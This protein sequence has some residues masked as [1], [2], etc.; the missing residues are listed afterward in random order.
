MPIRSWPQQPVIFFLAVVLACCVG[1]IA[2]AGEAVASAA[3]QVDLPY[4]AERSEPI[5]H[6]VDFSV[7]V[8]PP[9]HCKVL[10]VWLPLP[11]SDAAQ[12]ISNRKIATFPEEVEPQIDSEPVFGNRFA[13]FE[14]HN[15]HGGQIIRHRFSAKVWNLHWNLDP[16][17]VAPPEHWPQAFRPYLNPQSSVD[18]VQFE[19]LLA[20]VVP[21]RNQTASDLFSVMNW[22][23]A[24]LTY[25]H[26]SASLSADAGR[27]L[28][29]RRGHCSDYHGLCATLGRKLG[30]PA[31]VT[32]GLA[33]FPKNSPSHCKLEAYLPP[34]GWVSFDLSETQKLIKRIREDESVSQSDKDR[35]ST[36]ARERLHHGFR[37]NSWLLVTKGTNYELA[38]KA[39]QPVSVIR[40]IY[41]EADGKPLPD[42]D[43]ANINQRGYA[44][45]T[46]HKYTSDKPFKLPFKDLDTLDE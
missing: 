28:E 16:A 31:R 34:Y 35:L 11:Q 43:P 18:E 42:P 6:E 37:E 45:M 32:Y 17:H 26:A 21:Q 41:A 3:P 8:T 2:V 10:R 29:L 39:S 27:A 7:I 13:Y 5:T 20:D 9:Y 40:T 24:N 46:A 44:W 22:I 38:P 1:G 30:Y 23:D 4:Q 36:A 14:F 25:D 12:Q 15:P 19:R 33:L